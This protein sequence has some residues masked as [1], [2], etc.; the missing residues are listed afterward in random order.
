MLHRSSQD[1]THFCTRKSQLEASSSEAKLFIELSVFGCSSPSLALPRCLISCHAHCIASKPD[2]KQ[3]KHQNREAFNP[4][5]SQQVKVEDWAV[6]DLTPPTS[7]GTSSLLKPVRRTRFRQKIGG[8][9]SPTS[10]RHVAFLPWLPS[11]LLLYLHQPQAQNPLSKTVSLNVTHMCPLHP[12][13]CH[14]LML[15]AAVAVAQDLQPQP[16]KTKSPSSNFRLDILHNYLT[17]LISW[18]SQAARKQGMHPAP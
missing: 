8:W 3:S 4:C 5:R 17:D 7:R 15:V 6:E 13:S 18:S 2:S 9:C 12:P 10:R 16:C 11:M 14:E 1:F